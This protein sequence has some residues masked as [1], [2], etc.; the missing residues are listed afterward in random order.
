[1]SKVF[2]LPGI[3]CE[4][5]TVVVLIHQSVCICMGVWIQ[6]GGPSVMARLIRER[7]ALLDGMNAPQEQSTFFP[8]I[9]R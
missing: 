4:K 5:R 2:L 9:K 3:I 6:Q 7:R 1:M 8:P